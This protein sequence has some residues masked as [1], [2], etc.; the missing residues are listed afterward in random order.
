MKK[1]DKKK[2]NAII[3]ALT[4]ACEIAKDRGDGFEWLTHFVNYDR[5][6]QSLLVVCVYDTNEK[7][8]R[9]DQAAICALIQQHLESID[10]RVASIQRQ[11]KFDSEENCEIAN[12]GNW[13]ERLRRVSA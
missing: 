7:L 9:A 6:P 2:E 11:V 8:A 5:F 4:Q 3:A 13:D 10:I 12:N 1:S